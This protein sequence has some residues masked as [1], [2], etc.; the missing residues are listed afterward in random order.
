MCLWGSYRERGIHGLHGFGSEWWVDEPRYLIPVAEP[1]VQVGM[2]LEPTAVVEKAIRQA[3][4]AQRRLYWRP[5]RCLVAGAGPIGILAA[6][7]AR[8]R[9]L[10]VTVF[11]R[12]EKPERRSLLARAGVSYAA[13]AQTPLA[14]IA[15]AVGR[16]DL[17]IEA[18]GA[19]TVAF[20]LME[21][22]GTN[23]VLVLTSIPGTEEC[24]QVPTARIARQLVLANALVLGAVN[25][26][27][28]DFERGARDLEDVE[29]RW[30]GLLGSLKTRRVG[31]AQAPEAIVHDA[32]Q[33]KVVV[34][35][36]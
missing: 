2:L 17:A 23:G 36:S 30:P 14:D 1:L 32:R 7:V 8:L 29:Q 22:L 3:Y 13:T 11:E 27:R 5:E 35:L 25:A 24:T 28:V 6:L 26:H 15:R 4:E 9:G 20:E 34:E 18:T 10:A 16:I 31:L 19:A 33:I 21:H 12:T